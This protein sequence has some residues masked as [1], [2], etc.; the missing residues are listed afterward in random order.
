LRRNGEQLKTSRAVRLLLSILFL[1]TVTCGHSVPKTPPNPDFTYETVVRG[2][3]MLAGVS[4]LLYDEEW[5]LDYS[6]LECS[7]LQT[8]LIRKREDLMVK[9]W[10]D[11]C[12]A[13]G[14]SIALQC[15]VEFRDY[16]TLAPELVETLAALVGREQRYLIL[17][18]IER[19]STSQ[20]DEEANES[21]DGTTVRIGTKYISERDATVAFTVYDLSTGKWAWGTSIDGRVTSE[22]IERELTFE[23]SLIESIINLIFGGGSD[24]VEEDRLYPEY[25]DLAVALDEAYDVFAWQLPKAE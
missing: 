13:V 1:S 14:D 3:F 18:R 9:G 8:R 6:N 19:E 16:G 11:F 15:L 4:T 2:G 7:A 20:H 25:P 21:Q 24:D 5:P 22:R 12:R 17:T 10:G 23:E